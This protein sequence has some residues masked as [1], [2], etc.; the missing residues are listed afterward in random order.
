MPGHGF[1]GYVSPKWVQVG[2]LPQRRLGAIATPLRALPSPNRIPAWLVLPM[3]VTPAQSEVL[4]RPDNLGPN[5]KASRAQRRRYL[6][7]MKTGVPD[8]GNI[9]TKKLKRLG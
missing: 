3:V 2:N 4:L 5:L 1:F 8:I 6:A 9:A 7:R